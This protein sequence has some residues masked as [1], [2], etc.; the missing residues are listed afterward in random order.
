[1]SYLE[2]IGGS[3]IWRRQSQENLTKEQ[4]SPEPQPQP[5]PQEVEAVAEESPP[6]RRRRGRPRKTIRL[7][8]TPLGGSVDGSAGE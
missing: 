1:M 6:P 2:L 5:Q 4:A 3:H 8:E 7:E